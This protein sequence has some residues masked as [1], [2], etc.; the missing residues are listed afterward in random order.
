MWNL[1]QKSK[2]AVF[3]L[4]NRLR[5][6]HERHTTNIQYD[7]TYV[8]AYITQTF[9]DVNVFVCECNHIFNMSE[10]TFVVSAQTFPSRCTADRRCHY[11][12]TNVFSPYALT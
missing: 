8:Y 1:I 12:V 11:S 10:C 4:S 5:F 9:I 2:N 3:L 6:A 7:H